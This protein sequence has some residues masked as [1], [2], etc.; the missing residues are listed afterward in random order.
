MI[1]DIDCLHQ[2][3]VMSAGALVMMNFRSGRVVTEQ[4]DLT[5]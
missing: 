5:C 3:E 4:H 2:Q 1:E